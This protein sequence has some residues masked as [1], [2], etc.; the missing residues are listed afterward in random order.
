M[1][2]K[3]LCVLMECKCTFTTTMNGKQHFFSYD[4]KIFICLYSGIQAEQKI[5]CNPTS[6]GGGGIKAAEWKRF[7]HFYPVKSAESFFTSLVEW[8]N[9]E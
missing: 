9:E 4:K 6:G 5:T 2:Q 7:S 8:Q 1:A 3:S